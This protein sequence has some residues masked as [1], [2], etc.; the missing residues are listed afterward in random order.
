ME[1]EKGYKKSE[2]GQIPEDWEVKELGDV[3]KVIGGGAFKSSDSSKTGVKWLKIANV[4]INQTVWKDESFLPIKI[5]EE[6]QNFLL[7]E[8]DY[9]IALTRPILDRKL[10]I[11]KLNK[12]DVPALLNQRVGKIEIEENNDI[13][14]AYFLFQK[15]ET[16]NGLL[17]S[18][19]GTDPPNLSNKGIYGIKTMI[20]Q[21][22]SEQK[23]IAQVLSDTDNL[24]LALK[25][26]IAKKKLIKKGVMQKLL[27]PKEG[28]EEVIL[29]DVIDVNRGGSPR[30]IQ[31]YI[32]K[33]SDG[34]NWIKIGDTSPTSKY[35]VSAKEKIIQEGKN[36][37]REVKVGDFLLSN[38]MS[39][40][41]PYLLK[42]DG[43]I[44]DGWL[45]LQNY[46]DNFDTE[47]LYYLLTSEYVFNQYLSK[48]AGSGV[49][50]LNKELVSTVKLLKPSTLAEQ[51]NI[52]KILSDIDIE[53]EELELKLDKYRMAKQG[54]MQQL[55]TGKIRLV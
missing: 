15:Y 50:N 31:D 48:A 45:V 5:A 52:A 34:I 28:W 13:D 21:S 1:L 47:F 24:I 41:R 42:I 18:M 19:A 27:T 23:A 30:P 49:L 53:I 36:N 43:C 26:K 46:T 6:N 14:F 7:K 11:A 29:K 12:A 20:P 33:S 35:I 8:N 32:T 44:H 38:S 17:Q 55:L 3:L 4:S 10:K 37:S 9:V 40:G 22:E 25:K 16:I 51:I 2:L 54:M 39:F